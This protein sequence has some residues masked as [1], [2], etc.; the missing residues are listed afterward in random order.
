MTP[1]TANE[2]TRIA[3]LAETKKARLRI[4]FAMI[5]RRVDWDVRY[6]RDLIAEVCHSAI[7]RL[8]ERDSH[9]SVLPSA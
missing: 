4:Y 1:Q 9:P 7:R 5:R 6:D 3:E 2:L 8:T